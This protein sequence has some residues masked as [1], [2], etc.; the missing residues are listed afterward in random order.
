MKLSNLCVRLIAAGNR[1]QLIN[2][3]GF[4]FWFWVWNIWIYIEERACIVLVC[5]GPSG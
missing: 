5:S 1:R 2:L 3:E 4:G